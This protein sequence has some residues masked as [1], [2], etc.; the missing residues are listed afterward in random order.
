MKTKLVN[1]LT[2][3]GVSYQSLMFMC[4]GCKVWGASGLHILPVN[5]S[6]S[7]DR[8]SWTW[9]GNLELPTLSPSILSHY[10]DGDRCHS[11]LRNGLFEFLADSTHP[12]AG[13]TVDIPDL[14][15]WMTTLD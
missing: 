12:L 15:E 7:I 8:P 13:T 2:K 3:D 5:V 11:F 14:E 6:G 10:R 9:D 4:P 1:R